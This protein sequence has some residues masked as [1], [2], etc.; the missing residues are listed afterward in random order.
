MRTC[1][2]LIA[3]FLAATSCNSQK[4]AVP[5]GPVKLNPGAVKVEFFV[6]SQCPYGVQVENGVKEALE[7]LGPDVDFSLDFIGTDN[8]GQLS[9]MHGP[10]EVTGDIVQSC[11]AKLQPAGLAQF[12][13]CQNK[14]MKK[15][16]TTLE[17]CAA[18]LKL[19][20]TALTNCARGEEGKRLLQASFARAQAKGASGSPTMYIGGK[21]YNG[22]RTSTDF[23][24]AICAQYEK[25]PAACN[26]LPPVPQVNVTV[27]TD[28]RCTECNVDGLMGMLASQVGNPVLTRLDYGSQEGRALFDGLPNSKSLLLPLVLFDETLAA[29]TEASKSL[30]R[31]LRP[32]GKNMTLSVGA[33]FQ[34][35]CA[36]AQGCSLEECKNTLA[37]RTETANTLDLFVMSQCPYGVQALNSMDE[38]LTNFKDSGLHFNVHYIGDGTAKTGFTSMHGAEEVAEDLREVCA[39]AKYKKDARYMKY[40]LCRNKD[41]RSPDWQKCAIDGIEAK[42]IQACAEGEEGKQL[43]EEKMSLAKSLSIGASPTWLANGKFK[44]SGIDAETVRKNLCAH[45]AALKGCDK[46][47]SQVPGGSS[48]AGCK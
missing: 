15:V 5:L 27:L 46:T 41:I 21:P 39:M 47:L 38:V 7:K 32:L 6:M 25:K 30:A 3:A 11:V 28:T 42:A 19:D 36:D 33:S 2:V 8:N 13:A 17:S 34:P 29:D 45:N 26:S 16:A 1:I 48:A 43:L 37:C 20:V 35:A 4:N 14:D 24:R 10:D 23:L 12:L 18:E 22:R 40:V 31:Y 44:F 9:S